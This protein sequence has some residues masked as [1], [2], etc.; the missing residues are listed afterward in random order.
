MGVVVDGS[1]VGEGG[2]DGFP[3]DRDLTLHKE[4]KNDRTLTHILT[5]IIN[6]SYNI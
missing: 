1:L 5:A 6:T 2:P 4:K 3:L